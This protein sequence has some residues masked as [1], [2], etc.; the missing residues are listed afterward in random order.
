[1]L[2]G[3]EFEASLLCGGQPGVEDHLSYFHNS[4]CRISVCSLVS[5]VRLYDLQDV[6]ICMKNSIVVREC[7]R[8]IF[9][10]WRETRCKRPVF[11]LS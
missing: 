5:F 4:N 7:V 9:D 6:W 2:F 10:G 11:K 3:I 1:M 8:S